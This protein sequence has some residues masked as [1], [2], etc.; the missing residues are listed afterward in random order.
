MLKHTQ[1]HTHTHVHTHTY[2]H[3]HTHTHIHACRLVQNDE[4]GGVRRVAGVHIWRRILI[5]K[6]QRRALPGTNKYPH[7]GCVSVCLLCQSVSGFVCM[8]VCLSGFLSVCLRVC[9]CCLRN[10]DF[11]HSY[12]IFALPFGSQR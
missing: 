9:G 6:G 10:H 8:S 5:A 3:T 12:F 4:H 11:L 2:T 1:T 7:S